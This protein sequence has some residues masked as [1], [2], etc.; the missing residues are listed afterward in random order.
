MQG[1]EIVAGTPSAEVPHATPFAKLLAGGSAATLKQATDKVGPDT[2]A[3]FLFTSGS[4]GTPKGV[5]ITQRMI[6]ANMKMF[7]RFGRLWSNGRRS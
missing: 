2:I 6:N 1:R 5:I 7:D 4:T 3:K